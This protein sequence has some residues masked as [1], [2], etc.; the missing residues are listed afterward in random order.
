MRTGVAA[1]NSCKLLMNKTLILL[2]CAALASACGYDEPNPEET[3][4]DP[5]TGLTY[6]WQNVV[7]L[8][9]GCAVNRLNLKGIPYLYIVSCAETIAVTTGSKHSATTITQPETEAERAFR[10]RAAALSKLT[11]EERKELGQ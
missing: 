10:I 6:G 5:K 11:A 8:A 9:D 4:R 1:N 7:T 3:R 2:A